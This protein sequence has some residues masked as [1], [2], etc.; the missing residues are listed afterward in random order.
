MKERQQTKDL[1]E[2]EKSLMTIKEP[3]TWLKIG[4]AQHTIAALNLTEVFIN[5]A[6]H[7]VTG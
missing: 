4:K 6:A 5:F 3:G 7:S 2:S 1:I